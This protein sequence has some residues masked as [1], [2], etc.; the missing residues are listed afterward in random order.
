MVYRMSL[1]DRLRKRLGK[2]DERRIYRQQRKFARI[3]SRVPSILTRAMESKKKELTGNIVFA[4][5]VK[6]GLGVA[7]YKGD[8]QQGTYKASDVGGGPDLPGT[9]HATKSKGV[10]ISG[11]MRESGEYTVMKKEDTVY[12]KG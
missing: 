11:M 6:K 10:Q 2:S 9:Y 12:I 1:I 8:K 5:T 4:A 7:V 3:A